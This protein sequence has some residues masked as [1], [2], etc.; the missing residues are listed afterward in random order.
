M[1]F[2]GKIAGHQP[3]QGEEDEAMSKKLKVAGPAT[4]DEIGAAY[5]ASRV[6]HERERLLAIRMGQQGEWTFEKIAHT[7]G[8]GRDTIVRW[9]RAYRQG[10]IPRLLERRYEG[11]R[12]KLSEDDKQAL[13]DGLRRGQWKT[14]KEIRRWLQRERGIELKLGGVYYWLKQLEARWKVPRKSHKKKTRPKKRRLHAR[15]YPS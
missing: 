9:V 15:L 11:R 14:A 3:R 13:V 5:Q 12:E 10:G 7:L 2:D 6:P 4:N 8:R 1:L